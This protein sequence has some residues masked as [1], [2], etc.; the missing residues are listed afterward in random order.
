MII[1]FFLLADCLNR[2]LA[3]L[4]LANLLRGDAVTDV[5]WDAIAEILR[6]VVAD[7]VRDTNGAV[8][9]WFVMHIVH[10]I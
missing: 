10:V 1:G 5:V 4:I 8:V 9:C 2:L 7:I 6:D 3:G